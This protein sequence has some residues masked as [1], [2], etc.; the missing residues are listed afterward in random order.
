MVTLGDDVAPNVA[1]QFVKVS[2]DAIGT[3]EFI[4]YIPERTF[5][6]DPYAIGD[7]VQAT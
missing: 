2:L 7:V 1:G 5:F 6:R 3:D 4:A